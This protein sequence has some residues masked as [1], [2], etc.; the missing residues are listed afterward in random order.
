MWTKDQKAVSLDSNVLIAELWGVRIWGS[1]ASLFLP[2]KD[3]Y[4]GIKHHY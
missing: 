3:G 2:P 1:S 4:E